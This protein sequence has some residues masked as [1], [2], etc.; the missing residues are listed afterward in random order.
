[1]RIVSYNV[2][3]IRALARKGGLDRLAGL[4]ADIVCLQEVRADKSQFTAALASAPGAF[5]SSA[6][7]ADSQAKG[8]NGVAILTH[9]EVLCSATE[10]AG[11]ADEGRWVE[12]LLQSELGRVW[13]VCAYIPKGYVGDPRQERKAAFL[14]AMTARIIQLSQL[15]PD[16]CAGVLV[17]SDLNIAH[18]DTDLKNWKGRRGQSGVLPEERAV[19]DGWQAEGWVDVGRALSGPVQGP[20]TWWSQRGRAFDNDS[21]WRIDA[22]WA[23]PRLAAQALAHTIDKPPSW[24]ARWSDHAAVAVDFGDGPVPPESPSTAEAG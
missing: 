2:N 6:V 21:G 17:A 13:V 19:L 15:D 11:F 8:R 7:F 12:A 14:A 10:L 23:T 5:G 1:M 18:Q 4:N 9:Y 3:G 20:Y 16:G 22:I 24:D